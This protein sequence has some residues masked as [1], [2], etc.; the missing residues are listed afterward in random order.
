M[1]GMGVHKHTNNVSGF[2]CRETSSHEQELDFT[3]EFCRT[4]IGKLRRFADDLENTDDNV[5]TT[6]L[7]HKHTEGKNATIGNMKG[8]GKFRF[9]QIPTG[10]FLWSLVDISCFRA[11]DCP[12]LDTTKE[13]FKRC[14]VEAVDDL[15]PRP[16]SEKKTHK[17]KS[18]DA[19]HRCLIIVAHVEGVAVLTVENG[20]CEGVRGNEVMDF[21]LEGM[22]SFDLRPTEDSNPYRPR[23]QLWLKPYGP[24]EKWVP[25]DPDRVA[26]VLRVA[27]S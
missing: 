8:L 17:L 3:P 24:N 19:I 25:V 13:H 14:A 23:Y 18:I 10:L 15:A 11:S 6:D 20:N 22:D 12:I 21:I 7:L 26:Q 27:F 16:N 5:P 9:P 4:E 2:L 1:K